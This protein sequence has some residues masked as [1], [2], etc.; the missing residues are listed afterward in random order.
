MIKFKDTESSKPYEIFKDYY[1][2]ASKADQL[3]I[4]AICISS[5]IKNEVDSRFVNLKYIIGDEWIF[6]SNY[7][8][9][10]ALQFLDNINIACVFY[11]SKTNAQI[12]M[13]AKIKKTNKFFSDDYFSKRSDT[14]NALA[15]SSN[16]SR[17]IDSY[18][19]VI[20]SYENTLATE[21]LTLRPE[22]WG[23][24]SFTPHYFEFWEGHPSRLNK[25]L[26]FSFDNGV[27]NKSLIQP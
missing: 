20:S 21:N 11:W 9:P 26:A 2:K 16:Q 5:S 12:R 14:K 17:P 13:K 7:N 10:K 18:E 3:A 6:F 4:E 15:I 24:Y 23:G 25:R 8:S 1:E 27:W 19:D 22:Y